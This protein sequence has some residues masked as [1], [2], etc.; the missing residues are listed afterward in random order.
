MLTTYSISPSPAT[1]D[2]GA[3]SITFTVTRSSGLP[4]ETIYASTLHGSTNGYSTNSS[5]YTGLLNQAVA[6]SLNQA[7]K[8]VSVAITND[9][10]PEGNET[11][12]FIV[13]RSS[14]DAVT[15]YLAK[16]N[17]TIVDN[18]SVAAPSIGSVSPTSM[19]PSTSLQTLTVSGS[20]FHPDATLTFNPPTGSDILSTASRF[21]SKSSSQLVYQINN[22]NDVGTWQVRVNNPDGQSS[23]WASFTVAGVA[24]SISGVSPT[25]MPA[26]NTDQTL[27]ISGSNFVSGATLTF[28][29]PT[30][31]NI[32]SNAAKLT[33][34]SGSRITYQINNAGDTGTWAV[35]VNNPDGQSSDWA[36][37]TV[38]AVVPSISS[39][40]P[41]PVTGSNSDQPF[42]INGSNFST[43]ATVTLRD[44]RT[45]QVFPDRRPSSQSATHITINP[46]FTTT[47]ATWSVEVINPGPSSSGQYTFNVIAPPVTLDRPVTSG[48]GDLA[49]PGTVET[50]LAPAFQWAVVPNAAGYELNL[51]N[52]DT[53]QYVINALRIDGGSTTTY[54]PPTNLPAGTHFTWDLRAFNGT[55]F[56]P[57]AAN[58]YF[59]TQSTGAVPAAPSPMSPGYDTSPGQTV[60]TATPT[61]Q[62][63]AMPGVDKFGIYVSR[64][65]ADGT[66]ALVF[67]SQSLDINIPGSATSYQLP[68]QYL[69]DGHQ[70]RWNLNA[71]NAAGWGTYSARL[72]FRFSTSGAPGI[73]TG[74]TATP[75]G[76][77]S[78]NLDWPDVPNA[79]NYRLFRATSADG[80]WAQQ[81]YYGPDS[82]FTDSLG[83]LQPNTTYYYRVSAAGNGGESDLSVVESARTVGVV[84]PP[85]PTG[86][87][88]RVTAPGTVALNWDNVLSNGGYVI[89]RSSSAGG[90]FVPLTVVQAPQHSYQDTSHANSTPTT[91]YRYRVRSAVDDLLSDVVDTVDATLSIAYDEVRAVASGA[92]D[93]VRDS[94]ENVAT[95]FAWD[96]TDDEDGPNW[97]SA[98]PSQI[99]WSKKTIILTH[100]WNDRLNA[101]A[102]D[103][104]MTIFATDFMRG[105]ERQSAQYNILAVD[106]YNGGSGLGSNP[107]GLSLGRD[108]ALFGTGALADANLSSL[109]GILAAGPLAG[110]LAAAGIQPSKVALIGHSNGAGFM[111][112]LAYSLSR[113]TGSDVKEL[114]A[115]DAPW[116]TLAY[117]AVVAAA[118]SADRVSNYYI[119]LT[120]TVTSRI[121][122]PS[123]FD[124]AAGMGA[125][126]FFHDNVKNFE[127]HNAI[128]ATDL[129][130][131]PLSGVVV[132][133]SKVPL[134]FA[135]TADAASENSNP[136]GFKVSPFAT[137][138]GDVYD[139]GLIWTE[140]PAGGFGV[141]LKPSEVASVVL[142]Q[143]KD[144]SKKLA[145]R[146]AETSESMWDATVGGVTAA[147]RGV[148]S[149]VQQSTE[150]VSGAVRRWIH[151]D[152]NSP[153]LASAD[154]QIP[155]DAAMLSFDV[156]VVDEGN[157]DPLLVAVGDEVIGEVDL[158]LHKL[159]GGG[160]ADFWIGEHAGDTATLHFYMPSDRESSADFTIS[161][162]EFALLDGGPPTANIVPVSPD[163][164]TGAVD[165]IVIR[166]SE[167][168]SGVDLSDVRLSLDGGNNLLTASQSLSSVDGI[169]WTVGNLSSLTATLGTYTL[170]L[171]TSGSGIRDASGNPLAADVTATFTVV[172]QPPGAQP[173]AEGLAGPGGSLVIDG[174]TIYFTD[175]SPTEG[176]VKKVAVSGGPVQTL[177]TGLQLHDSGAY[178]GAGALT[179]SG[180]DLFGHYGGYGNLN[181]FRLPKSGGQATTI[182]SPGGGGL[183]GVF[184]D[185]AYYASNF[186]NIER[187]PVAGGSA[188]TV[189]TGRWVRNYTVDET[190]IYFQDYGDRHVFRFDTTTNTL[191]PLITGNSTEDSLFVDGQY[192]YFNSPG[193]LKRVPKEGGEVITLLPAG[194]GRGY[195]SDGQHVYFVSGSEIR[196]I[197][198]VGGATEPLVEV[199]ETGVHGLTLAGDY[200]YWVDVSAGAGAGRILRTLKSPDR[201]APTVSMVN[202]TP[203]PRTTPVDSVQVRF[204]EVVS[205]FNLSDLSLTRD[206]GPN[207]LTAAQT[208]TS[209]GGT[210][211][212][213][214]NLSNLTQAAGTYTLTLTAA[215]SGITDVA[216]NLLVANASDTW[217]I[218]IAIPLDRFEANDSFDTAYDL[219]STSDRNE[220]SLTIHSSGDGDY[221]RF[222][223]AYS[224]RLAATIYFDEAEGPLA[225]HMYNANRA[226]VAG[227]VGSGGVRSAFEPLVQGN[228]YYVRVT[229]TDGVRSDGYNLVMDGPAVA[230]VTG[231]HV[232]YNN[233]VYDTGAGRT[234]DTAVAPDKTA[235]LAG[236]TAS[237]ANITSYGRGINGVM[238]D[239]L[240]LP[241]GTI[242]GGLLGV[243]DVAIRTS[244]S[245][246]P[247]AWSTGPAPT[248][249]TVRPGAGVGGSDRVTLAW[250]DGTIVNRWVEVTLLANTDTGLAAPD[251]FAFGN[252]VGDAD[253][254]RGVNISDFGALRQDFGRTGLSIANGRSDFNRDGS[255]NIADFGA[256]RGNFG[257]SLA[258]PPTLAAGAA[259]PTAGLSSSSFTAGLLS[260][261][262]EEE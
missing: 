161:N 28:D 101:G 236:Q 190:C 17:F 63:A 127:L 145:A 197:P 156:T 31:S 113:V 196:K 174:Q 229:G 44:L 175:N 131:Q 20:G 143:A 232:F 221:F 216:G 245:T 142:E 7:Q 128:P 164:R 132:D 215:G 205:G 112:S 21:T 241:A 91:T 62:W 120:Q 208:L 253:S 104:F 204:D 38:A 25:S 8:T 170:T 188:S 37:F 246:A 16:A 54:T 173:V 59:R 212:T 116:L 195:A 163:P 6:F 250:A 66:Y 26:S 217:T 219:G 225:I 30:G 214:G 224:G 137:G 65:Q 147:V 181:V 185:Y 244:S 124:Q 168:V 198:V 11:F 247:N 70:Y 93:L 24:P 192:L 166:F 47:A 119:P 68:A 33:F 193:G 186:S 45:G 194:G 223:A 203:D 103:D 53:N 184:G 12:G 107:N 262:D 126:I 105:R 78:I 234:D 84:R 76:S 254:S 189:L 43:S 201:T 80:P 1:V 108:F 259:T 179:H 77:T 109:N 81:V 182:A 227:S 243:N 94:R 242:T 19:P 207:L 251:V 5:D 162:I 160:T 10:V 249:V 153:V 82:R 222:T 210:V 60:P 89:E 23:G 14:A 39:V 34:D 69:Q 172:P 202:V 130:K 260:A 233:S 88:A 237:A 209:A 248:S 252:L 29:P 261:A 157:G 121:W 206:G 110:R 256:L 27:T 218:Q 235:L 51:R 85:V 102:R 199:P 231:R 117:G 167:P 15:T 176:T 141:V 86:L 3:G 46:T 40:S 125:P 144:V 213:L 152:A 4:A 183:L 135:E 13:Q 133:H 180:P 2:E 129:Y 226:E 22:G 239:V 32:N 71:H 187:V 220:P 61:M 169:I 159:N 257:K 148:N 50:D 158:T 155:S 41:N 165:T 73:P 97:T 111:A 9:S 230:T 123:R 98:N 55:I 151:G 114:T 106:W 87:S 191:T 200:L 92:L 240:G 136:W 75:N 134:R 150:A 115:L 90:E 178:R 35:R 138:N 258:A 36:S 56:S 146:V 48:P 58:R 149:F 42:T 122:R 96:W 228:T 72:Y 140:R 52:L 49:A 99:D 154:V 171:T 139:G 18:D 74:L 177:A 95:V 64:R 238:V 79:A 211:Y 67:D 255:V 100:G 118:S 57:Y 83:G